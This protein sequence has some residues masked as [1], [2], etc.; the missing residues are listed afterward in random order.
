MDSTETNKYYVS[1]SV[2]PFVDDRPLLTH[3][4]VKPYVIAILLHRG[5]VCRFEVVSAL[6]PHCAEYDLRC[7]DTDEP[8][9][10]IIVDE[11]L[12]QMVADG[13]LRHNSDKMTWV[14]TLGDNKKNLPTIINWVSTLGGALPKHLLYEL[15]K[16]D[17]R[18]QG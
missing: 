7:F 8:N 5:A 12:G 13:L 15:A 1:G 10:E 3:A 14:L 16:N 9:V 2:G 6:V 4:A 18:L 11:V 17:E